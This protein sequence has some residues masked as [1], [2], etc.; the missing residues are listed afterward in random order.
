[1]STFAYAA[2]ANAPQ[3]TSAAAQA[4]CCFHCNEPLLGSVLTARISERNEP[5]CC[6]GC[7]AVAELIAGA[8][9]A[10]YYRFREVAGARPDPT[11]TA[12]DTWTALN[13]PEVAQQFIRTAGETDS[14]VLAVDGLRCAACSWLI[15]RVLKGTPG[16][17]EATINGATGRAYVSWRRSEAALGDICRAIAHLGYRPQPLKADGGGDLQQ[18]ERR[19]ALKHLAVAGFGMM[20]VMMF[21]VAVYC[22]NLAGETIDAP[23]LAFFRYVSLLVATPVMFYAAAPVFASAQR[24]LRTR[25]VGM[26]VPVTIALVLAYSASV[27][28]T[29][30]GTDATVYFDSV[31]MFIFFLTLA[32]FVQMSVRQRTV[33]IT[34][35]LARQLP[36]Y[37]HKVEGGAVCEVPLSALQPGDEVMVRLGEVLPADGELIDAEASIDEAML[38]GESLPVRRQAGERLA[39]G[40]LNV[41]APLRLRVVAVA[42]GTSLSHIASLQRRAQAQRPALAKRAD[43][44]AARFLNY[45]LLGAGLTCAFWLVVD[46]TR[47]FE[48][49]LSVLVVACPCAFAIAMPAAI[50]AVTA[51]LAR[52]GVLVTRVD[53]LETLARVDQF[54]FDK[55][56]TLTQGN[57]ALSRCVPL[58]DV[59][60]AQ[61]LR[62][63]ATLEVTSEHPLARAFTGFAANQRAEAVRAVPGGGLEGIVDGCVYRI[64]TRHFVAQLRSAGTPARTETEWTGT[65]V[66]LGDSRQEL[67]SFE[68]HD[69]PRLSALTCIES[70]RETG[71]DA[72]ILSGDSL[73]A[74]A[75]LAMRCG[76]R[77]YFARHSPE[78]KLAHVQALQ[79]RG[80]RVAMI[81]DGV[82]DAPVLAAADLSIA[83]GRG[84]ALAHASADMLLV[85][86]NL[87]CLP[88]AIRL[89]RKANRIARQN[90]L[91]SALYNFGSL[92]LAAA[93]LV[94]PWLAALGMS[95][96]SIAVVLNAAR[97]LPPRRNRS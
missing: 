24:N 44:A 5:V 12:S 10:D 47:A 75:A 36:S 3:Q 16:V 37:A 29:F 6:H 57:V 34:E 78:Q 1:M 40:T 7:R 63:A 96:S 59:S 87:D 9:L 89:A 73:P 52:R 38:T 84:A 43:A 69:T 46:P 86:E 93:G 42:A 26:D 2:T 67:A 28:N 49:T 90:L 66:V 72:Q 95:L 68:L 21:A 33:E 80:S 58:G 32:R 81:G 79:A 56:G 15:D 61:C 31:T 76:V 30:R 62:I 54:V 18:E 70:L 14:V 25:T 82:N 45:V 19:D 53:A 8:G 11:A 85:T 83:M 48:A 77:A 91:W 39:A 27:W 50:S 92:P 23:L 17:R 88:E 35:A 71:I 13:R 4:A 74:V 22:A 51:N 41:G 55:T 60:E 97:L 65:V 20:Q 94:S 64:G